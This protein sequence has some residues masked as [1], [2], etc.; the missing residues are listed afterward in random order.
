VGVTTGENRAAAFAERILG[1]RRARLAGVSVSGALLGTLGFVT[2]NTPSLLPRPYYLQGLIAGL[3]AVGGYAGGGVAG[4]VGGR[5][6]GWAGLQVSVKPAAR[7]LL[8][9]A[10]LAVLG[11]G[12]LA[13]PFLTLGWQRSTAAYVQV[14]SPGPMFVVGSIAVASAVFALLVWL[15][16]LVAGLVD[17]F[18]V[19]LG[20]RILREALARTIATVLTLTVV[21]AVLYQVI[22]L[23]LVAIAS[24]NADR[25]NDTR[26]QGRTAP[27]SALRSGGPGSPYSWE[28]LGQDGAIFVSGGPT[29]AD[30]AR[31]A[32]HPAYEPIRIFV[33]TSP[34][35]SQEQ[36]AAAVVAEMDRTGAFERAAVLVMS[37]TSTGYINES[38]ASA[39]EYL[40]GGDTAIV[41]MQYSTLPSAIDLLTAS[42][43]APTAGRLLF[44]A[45]AARVAG[46]PSGHR[47]KLYAGGESLGA[48]AGDGA[49]QTPAD[50]LGRVDGALW[51]GTPIF[52]PLR[53]T[54]TDQRTLGSAEVNP[55]VDNGRHVRFVGAPDQ[56]AADKFGRPYGTWETPRVV[57]LQ[58]ESDPV[59]W[60]STD[61]LLHTP[62]WLSESRTDGPMSLM[63]WMP[64]V[65]FWQVTADLATSNNVPGGFGHRYV[66]SETVP[67]WAA[68]F[69]FDPT[70]DHTAVVAAITAATE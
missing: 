39:F 11:F 64:G 8:I 30:I 48:Y 55:V 17:W 40:Q 9:L 41:S 56:L 51:T 46:M 61:L 49:F 6:A 21:A 63:S 33:G 24:R 70:A 13:F 44:N 4:A 25:V 50:M 65:T 45:V 26:P 19:H 37:A 5:L 2:S 58:H 36:N 54:L 42:N 16:R 10:W 3:C 53:K 18:T 52:A 14:P 60:W 27:T 12:V 43:N 22:V 47:P 28:S 29:Q 34:E 15:W 57:Y 38:S 1:W 66:A 31:V 20:S 59:A 67:A 69:G 68:V 32:G 62:G 23:G 35:R 7:R